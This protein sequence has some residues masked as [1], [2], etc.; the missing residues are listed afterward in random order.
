RR[1]R[2]FV[3]LLL[4][5]LAFFALAV[6]IGLPVLVLRPQK[7]AL[8]FTLGSLH[9]HRSFGV[10]R[11]WRNHFRTLLQRERLPFTA[12]YVLTMLASLHAAVVSR[13]FILTIICAG[14]QCTTLLYYLGSYVPGGARG[15]RIFLKTVL[16]NSVDVGKH[17]RKTA[18]AQTKVK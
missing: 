16:R 18:K 12:A 14:L 13:S 1:F 2:G 15:V 5:S 9:A 3:L 7:F 6:F 8:C 4:I 10:L 17:E 11:G